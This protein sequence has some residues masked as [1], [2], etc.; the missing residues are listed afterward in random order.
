M[1]FVNSTIG[2]KQKTHVSNIH[3]FYN[4][5]KGVSKKSRSPC[6]HSISPWYHLPTSQCLLQKFTMNYMELT[7]CKHIIQV[8][9]I[10]LTKLSMLLNIPI[11]NCKTI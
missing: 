7:Y 10:N 4:L 2:S 6:T 11:L 9:Q 1:Y 5:K 8:C 3:L